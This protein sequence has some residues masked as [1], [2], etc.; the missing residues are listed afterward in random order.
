MSTHPKFIVATTKSWNIHWANSVQVNLSDNFM[1]PAYFG[2]TELPRIGNIPAIYKDWMKELIQK[3]EELT[4][5]NI[6]GSPVDGHSAT[7]WPQYIFF[8][9][10]S[11]KIPKDVYENVECI[12]FH[13]TDLPYGR[14]GSPLQNLI[15]KGLKYTQISAFRVV[16]EMD[17]GPIYLKHPLSLEGTS[18]EI[19]KRASDYI[20]RNMIPYI[21]SN[22]PKPVEQYG[23]PTKFKRR[24]P[25]N[26]N[27]GG[28]KKLSKVY[29]YIR[30]LD[31]EG[32][33][34]AFVETDGLRLQFT[35]AKLK[36]GEV[37]A[38]VK[39]KVK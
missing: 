8:P 11:W 38:K 5:Y 19:L 39:I 25:S 9:H 24:T 4:Y 3:K 17:A 34:P 36:A 21:L 22:K 10:W 23:K 15:V 1:P 29:D 35:E 27:L 37:E 28:L 32:Y 13:M 6:F 7:T 12:V 14:G 18:E 26:G 20:F 30:M 16:D 31:G 33:P 2:H